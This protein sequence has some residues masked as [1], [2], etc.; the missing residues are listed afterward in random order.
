M[1]NPNNF[2]GPSFG[3]NAINL[4]SKG[5]GCLL[6]VISVLIICIG[7]VAVLVL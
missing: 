3:Q 4:L 6:S 1:K 5:G 7:L 2:N